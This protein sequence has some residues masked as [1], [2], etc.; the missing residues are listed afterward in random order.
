MS[1]HPTQRRQE[2]ADDVA[3][4]EAPRGKREKLVD[5]AVKDTFPAS[6]PP[7]FMGAAAT[8]GP[9]RGTVKPGTTQRKD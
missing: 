7:S 5:K 2:Q 3:A 4:K 9:K 6:D 1:A 8:G